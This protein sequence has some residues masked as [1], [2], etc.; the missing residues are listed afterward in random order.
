MPNRNM[1]V[2]RIVGQFRRFGPVGPVY[3]VLGVVRSLD[4][5]DALLRVRIIETGEEAEYRYSHAVDDPKEN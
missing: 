1:D 4:D 3:E 2:E 5:Y